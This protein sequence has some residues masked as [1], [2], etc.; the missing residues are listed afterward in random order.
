[1]RTSNNF[2]SLVSHNK[3][4]SK[5]RGL[6]ETMT[7]ISIFSRPFSSFPFLHPVLFI[8][9][10]LARLP[11]SELNSA[12][13]LMIEL[14]EGFDTHTHTH[15]KACFN[16]MFSC[17]EWVGKAFPLKQLTATLLSSGEEMIENDFH[18]RTAS[19]WKSLMLLILFDSITSG[20]PISL[21]HFPHLV[22]YR[23]RRF[24]P[25]NSSRTYQRV[26]ASPFFSIS[27]N[28]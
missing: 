6:L 5:R 16:A 18:R 19:R 15:T 4:V 11:T 27:A 3:T 14:N 28:Q 23:R 20:F 10:D 24:R 17:D 1:M 2:P 8:E 26:N 9:A 22:T 21:I 12:S 13:P 7:M 25:H